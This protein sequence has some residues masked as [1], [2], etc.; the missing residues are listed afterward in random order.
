MFCFNQVKL[1]TKITE[2]DIVKYCGM[3]QTT[4]VSYSLKCD[5][6]VLESPGQHP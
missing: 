6:R 3:M 1:Y 2:L 4:V 5:I